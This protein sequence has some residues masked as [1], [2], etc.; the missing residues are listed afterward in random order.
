M[1]GVQDLVDIVTNQA[2]LLSGS[3]VS[4]LLVYC[5]VFFCANAKEVLLLYKCR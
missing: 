2:D 4:N 3:K 1:K 5:I